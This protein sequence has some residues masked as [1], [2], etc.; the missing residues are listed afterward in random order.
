MVIPIFKGKAAQCQTGHSGN[1]AQSLDANHFQP[2]TG[3]DLCAGATAEYPVQKLQRRGPEPIVPHGI[4]PPA[5]EL[6]KDVGWRLRIA[7]GG[8]FDLYHLKGT[9]V[10]VKHGARI[11]LR[12][13]PENRF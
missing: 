7:V 1:I 5:S 9:A 8:A 13:K 10:V 12:V 4:H 11:A 6:A 2:I 3:S